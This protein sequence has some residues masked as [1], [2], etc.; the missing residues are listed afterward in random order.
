MATKAWYRSARMDYL[1][2]VVQEELAHACMT[3]LGR[4]GVLQLV[5][6]NPSKTA[7][8]RRYVAEI[9]RI[10]QVERRVRYIEEML[11]KYQVTPAPAPSTEELLDHLTR[12]QQE[13]Q[14]PAALLADLEGLL[15]EKERELRTLASLS[16]SLTNEF[17]K[18]LEL[19]QVL[20]KLRAFA[21]DDPNIPE[22][23]TNMDPDDV[24]MGA[25]QQ[26]GGPDLTL[27]FRFLAGTIQSTEKANFERMIF[28]ATRGNAYM[29]FEEIDEPIVDPVTALPVKKSVFVVFFQASNI[30]EKIVAVCRAFQAQT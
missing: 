26:P 10:D 18:N 3:E 28:R 14:T 15:S 8:Q 30:E 16:A 12:R 29:R 6:L 1:S 20:H 22:G 13:G 5:D 7:F 25:G 2:I 23:A 11:E 21:R 9:S 17:N 24:Q 27:R 4:L 19:K